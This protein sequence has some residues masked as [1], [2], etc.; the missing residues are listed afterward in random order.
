M[1]KILFI[2]LDK[3]GDLVCTMC[4]DDHPSLKEDSKHWLISKGLEFIPEHSVPKRNY[5]S[6]T[7]DRQGFHDL[8]EIL[9]TGLFDASVSFQCPWW[10]HFLL[11]YFRIPIRVGVL[12]KWHSFLFLNAGLRQ[13]RSNAEIHE[14]DYNFQ[15]VQILA[16]KLHGTKITAQPT[17]ILK[18]E[19]GKNEIL[20]H[21]WHLKENGY[22]II[23]PGMAGSAL[24]WPQER[25]V[26]FITSFHNSF[27]DIKIVM[28]GTVAD[29]EYLDEILLR[30]E[31]RDF[32]LSLHGKVNS[33][34]LLSLLSSSTGILAPSTGV[35]HLAA[36]LGV[37]SFGIFSPIK[38]QHPKRWAPRGP[39]T[40][41]YLPKVSCPAKH[42]CLNDKCPHFNCMD[43]IDI[44]DDFKL[45]FEKLQT[46]RQ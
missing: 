32:F 24:N 33:F 15:L 20:L 27:P 28:T 8:Y 43:D 34:E 46:Q 5:S 2:R 12:S 36:S 38:V 44:F 13:K 30:F 14:S 18:M 22:F 19:A 26:Q 10:V 39:M 41:T 6:L 23:H 9:K 3:I 40:K 17:P 29:S 1:S 45:E 4:T 25:F 37:P 42:E 16:N 31:G 7:K 35:L 21:K 11:F